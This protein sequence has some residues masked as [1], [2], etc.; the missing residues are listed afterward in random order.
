MTKSRKPKG[1]VAKVAG[2]ANVTQ[3]A[4]ELLKSKDFKDGTPQVL[5][6]FQI[7][8]MPT[9]HAETLQNRIGKTPDL[10]ERFPNKR[11]PKRDDFAG[12]DVGFPI[13]TYMAASYILAILSQ[14][15]AEGAVKKVVKIVPGQPMQTIS[16]EA[17]AGTSLHYAL[18]SKKDQTA[19]QNMIASL[20]KRYIFDLAHNA[21][22]YK[23]LFEEVLLEADFFSTN[24]FSD[25]QNAL[26]LT[27]LVDLNTREWNYRPDF[28]SDALSNYK[29]EFQAVEAAIKV[30]ATKLAAALAKKRVAAQAQSLNFALPEALRAQEQNRGLVPISAWSVG[31]LKDVI[32]HD[33][34]SRYECSEE[35]TENLEQ[36]QY[37][38]DK[39]LDNVIH[40]C[41]KQ[42]DTI[43]RLQSVIDRKLIIQEKSS[44]L[45][46]DSCFKLLNALEPV[47]LLLTNIG[48][49]W[50]A[51]NLAIKAKAYS[52]ELR[53]RQ[54]QMQ[55]LYGKT[56]SGKYEFSENPDIP[57]EEE[58]DPTKCVVYACFSGSDTAYDVIQD[59]IKACGV[60]E[61]VVVIRERFEALSVSDER[62]NRVKVILVNT[63]CSRTSVA[64][65]IELLIQESQPDSDMSQL[66]NLKPQGSDKS[67]D[68][69][70]SKHL[71][72]MKHAICGVAPNANAIVYLTRSV[73]TSENE[74]VVTDALKSQPA[75]GQLR[76][77][78]SPPVVLLRPTDITSSTGN[79]LQIRPSTYENGCFITVLSR[80]T[81]QKDGAKE[82]VKKA[83]L[84]GLIMPDKPNTPAKTQA[85]LEAERQAAMPSYAR[86]NV[87]RVSN[88]ISGFGST[89][90]K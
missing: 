37:K 54:R 72:T 74:R 21:L 63:D 1:A 78:L 40:F 49:G 68:A 39:N 19:F 9:G 70:A 84:Q 87:R 52:D 30:S 33:E 25:D 89:S 60:D 44:V 45:A 50:T 42:R 5:G 29:E 77:K 35:F 16:E 83:A 34:F 17:D 10:L 76:W 62:L 14:R 22:K 82:M 69:L 7:H 3:S 13:D 26:L 15:P 41:G 88:G 18:P 46:V 65:P 36:Y 81:D 32:S 90:K 43:L 67:A 66:L 86:S 79:Y 47:D 55:F 64:D 58:E 59:R 2:L 4:P 28:Q 38:L 61:H 75:T 73:H 20:N 85:Q 6:E 57:E 80:K 27:Y 71:Q 23:P 56:P 12:F 31:P 51:I 53:D 24:P 11:K 8:D 48:S